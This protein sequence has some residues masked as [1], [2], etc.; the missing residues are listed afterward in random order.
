MNPLYGCLTS[1]HSSSAVS[2]V[3]QYRSAPLDGT[4]APPFPAPPSQT[5]SVRRW[6]LELN[7]ANPSEMQTFN[8]SWPWSKEEGGN[9]ISELRDGAWHADWHTGYCVWVVS[10]AT[11]LL[12]RTLLWVHKHTHYRPTN[13]AAA[14]YS[15]APGCRGNMWESDP[16][17]V[18][19]KTHPGKKWWPTSFKSPHCSPSAG[20]EPLA[21]WISILCR[22]VPAFC[23]LS[24]ILQSSQRIKSAPISSF[25]VGNERFPV[26][27]PAALR[28]VFL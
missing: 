11:V 2:E 8:H 28:C 14:S 3:A 6:C 10:P 1:H 4:D 12:N 27:S 24:E 16:P 5:P 19:G 17:P 20:P 26:L 7:S 23:S 9:N 25:D 22:D 21:N 18:N 13:R 15:M